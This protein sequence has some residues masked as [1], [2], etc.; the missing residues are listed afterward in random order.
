[1]RILCTAI[2]CLISVSIHSQTTATVGTIIKTNL[3]D[4]LVDRYSLGT[5][6]IIQNQ[7]SLGLDVDYISRSVFV[8]SNNPWYLGADTHKQGFILEPQARYYIRETNSEG[9][10]TSISGFFGYA[11][12][13]R[14]DE[15]SWG[16]SPPKWMASG[17]S[18][19]L[20][21][22][23]NI[24]RLIID[25]YMGATWAKNQGMGTFYEDRA[26]FPP[27]NGWRISGGLRCGFNILNNKS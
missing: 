25:I 6:V 9:L 13:S 23:L 11:Q 24:K 4:I 1:M 22:Q 27:P 19:H 3:T 17:F 5:E 21:H 14:F 2:T 10:Y 12:Y 20:G 26:L 8:G 18:L 15:Q 16:V 7:F